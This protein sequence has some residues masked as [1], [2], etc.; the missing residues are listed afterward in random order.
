MED[1]NFYET[2]QGKFLDGFV[3]LAGRTMESGVVLSGIS[4]IKHNHK[5]DG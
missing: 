1:D 3:R 2:Q 4:R 5:E